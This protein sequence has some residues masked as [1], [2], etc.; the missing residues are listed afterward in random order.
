V[1]VRLDPIEIDLRDGRRIRIRE[2]APDDAPALSA[3]IAQ[4]AEDAPY[5]GM[6]PGETP[7]PEQ[8]LERLADVD[9]RP[10]SLALLGEA[11]EQPGV[12]VGDCQLISWT[13]EKTRHSA[14]VGM[15]I[16]A[17]WQGVGLGRALLGA[18]VEWARAN[19]A[20]W[21]LDLGVAPEN[22][23]ALKLYKGLGFEV[24]G[25]KRWCFLQPDGTLIDDVCMGLWVGPEDQRPRESATR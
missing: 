12:V 11:V 3:F 15:G 13:R 18:A 1:N 25:R 22:E 2:S 23:A 6:N 14:S 17:G 9:S 19:P 21:R 24:E 20:L 8:V 4:L 7:T 5:I 16:V 10:G